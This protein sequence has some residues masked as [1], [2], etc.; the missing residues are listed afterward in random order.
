MKITRAW[1]PIGVDHLWRL[2]H[3]GFY[4]G[5]AF[6]RV[7][8]GFVLQFG[9]SGTPAMNA[10]HSAPIADDPVAQSNKQFTMSYATAGPGTRTTQLFINYKDNVALDAQGFAPVGV[11]VAGLEFL[12]RVHD[13]TPGDSNGVHQAQ[14]EA[15]GNAWVREAYPGISFV[16][17]AVA[18]DAG[19]AMGE[20][21]L[22]GRYA[23]GLEHVLE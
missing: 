22:G 7:V 2:V 18:R 5:S 6:T 20:A 12:S 15:K 3:V 8:G 14:Y 1:A 19:A 16:R 23:A 4:D 13:P 10:N 9:I 11:A 17:T 21:R